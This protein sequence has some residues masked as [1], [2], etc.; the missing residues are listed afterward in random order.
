MF[1]K[2]PLRHVPSRFA[3]GAA[4]LW[5]VLGSSGAVAAEPAEVIVGTN[6]NQIYALDLKGNQYSADF[7]IWFRWMD[8]NLK[9]LET[10]E[11]AKGRVTSK[12]GVVQK[13]IGDLNYASCR[14][15]ATIT[16]F[17]E[18][19]RF[20]LDDHILE[21]QFEDN[22]NEA[23]QMVY[24]P[25]KENSGVS[26]A[27]RVPG[28]VLK[29]SWPEVR[30]SVYTTNYGDTS[31]SAGNESTY[32]RFVSRFEI[33]RP[34]RSR[35]FKVFIA[36]LVATSI[37]YLAFFI[38]PKDGGSRISLGVGATSPPRQALLRSTAVCR[39]PTS[40]PR[41]NASWS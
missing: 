41:P 38:R 3:A 11:L 12:T 14:V 37:G 40:R 39:T 28:W 24:V 10:F 25:D 36:L 5:I 29:R 32:S 26:P 4:L 8:E 30:P 15:L 34:G 1:A 23:S 33:L 9:P 18:L 31:L 13:K 35:I 21:L 20:P 16:H 22:E 7:Y 6:L 27:V 19:A 2:N 17:W